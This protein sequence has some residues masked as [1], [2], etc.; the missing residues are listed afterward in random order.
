MTLMDSEQTARRTKFGAPVVVHV[1]LSPFTLLM[2]YGMGALAAN[3]SNQLK[4]PPG[5]WEITILIAV[6]LVGV[7][8][9]SGLL[10]TFMRWSREGTRG[11][12]PNWIYPL[13][14]AGASWAGVA[15]GFALRSWQYSG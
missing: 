7:G 1:I 10:R 5:W 6:F 12:L 4:T 11:L 9:W 15:I 3:I 14:W 13:L 2:W 8:L